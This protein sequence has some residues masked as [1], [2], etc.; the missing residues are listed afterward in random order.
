MSLSF[1][2]MPSPS[3]IMALALKLSTS[4]FEIVE[5]SASI[6]PVIVPVT[7]K[8]SLI[9]TCV[10]SAELISVPLI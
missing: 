7:C 10:E 6:E 4:R 1:D 9:V 2:P 3:V 5:L 8:F